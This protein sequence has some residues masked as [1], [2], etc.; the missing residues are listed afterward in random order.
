M[1]AAGLVAGSLRSAD[2]P[3][4]FVLPGLVTVEGMR[5]LSEDVSPAVEVAFPPMIGRIPILDVEP[6]RG[7]GTWPCKAV[8]GETFEVS[9][10]VFRE[11]HEMLGAAVVLCS[12]TG[13]SRPPIRLREQTPGTDRYAASVRA[14]SVGLWHFRVEAW[15][16]PIAHWRH[17]AEIKIP[18]GQVVDRLEL[19]RNP[20]VEYALEL[21]PLR[22][23]VTHT[24]WYPLLV[25]RERALF[26]SWYEFFPRSE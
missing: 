22:E 9:A 16:D 8:P 15:G 6:A 4:R 17:D 19:V 3:V 18:R 20:Q 12:P 13:S 14:D 2:N 23:H 7:C 26:G 5:P 1:A 24:E 21:R 11:G 10:T 25:H